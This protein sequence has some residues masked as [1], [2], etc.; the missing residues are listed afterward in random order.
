ML[1][2]VDIG[3]SKAKW[4]LVKDNRLVEFISLPLPNDSNSLPESWPL[5]LKMWQVPGDAQWIIASTNPPVS[6]RFQHWLEA[7]GFRVRH[8]SDYRDIP[9]KLNVD[10]PE[11]VGID[12]LLNAVAAIHR[13][14]PARPKLI[15][16]AGSAVTV[17]WVDPDDT[18]CG[19]AILPGFRLMSEALH[20]YTA[21]LPLV[22]PAHS[23]PT[24]PAKNT[25]AAI[26]VGM[27]AA[28]LGAINWLKQQY[29][30]T[31]SGSAS[32]PGRISAPV[33]FWATGTHLSQ[34][35]PDQCA[36]FLTGGDAPLL[37]PYLDP[38]IIHWPEMTL[39]G[40]YLA[41]HGC[42]RKADP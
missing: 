35:S 27:C 11:R 3:N 5:Q 38:A 22:K 19:G 4:G 29:L 10:Y 41:T 40:L 17:D 42:C 13:G 26:Q 20:R 2:L 23:L 18:F 31:F 15:V 7:Q 28:L 16:D 9:I 34:Q 37:A 14:P 21:R 1:I 30:A 24:I 25:E 6:K 33:S 39:E 36:C 8:L 32:C 12:R